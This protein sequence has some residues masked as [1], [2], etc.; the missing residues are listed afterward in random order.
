MY[1]TIH[2]HDMAMID[3]SQKRIEEPDAIWAY[4]NGMTGGIKR[5]RLQG[6]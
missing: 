3:L 6:D 4:T 5:L 1:P 2:S